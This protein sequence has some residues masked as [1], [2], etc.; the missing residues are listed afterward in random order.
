MSVANLTLGWTKSKLFKQIFMTLS[1]FIY[2]QSAT[3][4]TCTIFHNCDLLLVEACN[5]LKVK[6]FPATIN[7][8]KNSYV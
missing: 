7:H 4:L 2:C 8:C 5:K 3:D 6:Y 1:C